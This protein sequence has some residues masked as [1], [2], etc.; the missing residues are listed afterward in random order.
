MPLGG[1]RVTFAVAAAAAAMLT[2][3]MV[4]VITVLRVVVCFQA[5]WKKI[6]SWLAGAWVLFCFCFSFS[7]FPMCLLFKNATASGLRRFLL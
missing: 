4:V 1:R 5:G 3:L 7:F 2:V 6:M